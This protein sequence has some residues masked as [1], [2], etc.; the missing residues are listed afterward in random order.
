MSYKIEC[1]VQEIELDISGKITGLKIL[2]TE[3]YS[4]KQGE[5]KYNVFCP[6]N[7]PQKDDAPVSVLVLSTKTMLQ[8]KTSPAIDLHSFLMQAK[9]AGKKVRLEID[10]DSKNIIFRKIA[11]L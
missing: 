2:G 5:E 4:L 1:T 10:V 6:T 11:V 3:G 9:C 7:M 8:W